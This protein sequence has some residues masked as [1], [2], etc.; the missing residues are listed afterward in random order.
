MAELNQRGWRKYFKVADTSGQL[1][2]IS[3]KNQF[4]LAGYARNDGDNSAVRAD[5]VFRNYDWKNTLRIRK[6]CQ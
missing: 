2:P 1:S 3:G 5:F 6:H 4:G